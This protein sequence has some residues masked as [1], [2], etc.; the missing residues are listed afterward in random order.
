MATAPDVIDF[1][2][3]RRPNKFRKRFD[4]IGT[5]NNCRRR[6]PEG[7]N[8]AANPKSVIEQSAKAPAT[9]NRFEK[10]RK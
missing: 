8:A 5:V 7:A 3:A 6:Y 9:G 4:Q 10:S 1:L 2:V